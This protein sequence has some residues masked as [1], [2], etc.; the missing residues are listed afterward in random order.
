LAGPAEPYATF[1][2]S[3]DE[4]ISRDAKE[5]PREIT[6]VCRARRTVLE[7]QTR[8]P[9]YM[10]RSGREIGDQ[11]PIRVPVAS[12]HCRQRVTSHVCRGRRLTIS[13]RKTRSSRSK[14]SSRKAPSE[15]NS[16][17]SDI[18]TVVMRRNRPTV[19]AGAVE[20]SPSRVLRDLRVRHEVEGQY[21]SIRHFSL[22]AVNLSRTEPAKTRCTDA[23]GATEKRAYFKSPSLSAR[24]SPKCS[25]PFTPL[26][27]TLL[28]SRGKSLEMRCSRPTP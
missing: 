10:M 21:N 18:S 19:R 6:A 5:P 24:G 3:I 27:T 14:S 1:W 20:E 7:T 25:V 23:R 15:G 28:S 13:P 2:M 17:S 4:Y 12:Q 8:G 11:P 9:N 22:G 26:L 16:I